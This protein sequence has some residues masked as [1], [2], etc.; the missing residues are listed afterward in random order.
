[1]RD[2]PYKRLA[3]ADRAA[4]PSVQMRNAIAPTRQDRGGM[5]L[6]C[7]TCR[8]QFDAGDMEKHFRMPHGTIAVGRAR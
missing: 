2:S 1:M 6:R 8:V 4:F 3:R 5:Q 7:L